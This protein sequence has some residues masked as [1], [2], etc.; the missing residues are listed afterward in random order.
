MNTRIEAWLLVATI[1]GGVIG[2]VCTASSQDHP[3]MSARVLYAQ[4]NGSDIVV[5]PIRNGP[6]VTP[7][8]QRP[9]QPQLGNVCYTQYGGYPSPYLAVGLPC[10]V[11]LNGTMVPGRIG[12]AGVPPRILPLPGAQ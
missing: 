12:L 10:T 1:F 3:S 9:P 2:G 4:N 6:P 7:P 8:D 11:N 5:P